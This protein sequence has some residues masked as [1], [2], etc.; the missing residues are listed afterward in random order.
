M[1]HIRFPA[2]AFGLTCGLAALLMASTMTPVLA[3]DAPALAFPGAQGA[4]A[5]THGGRGGRIVRVTTLAA[6]GP[7]SFKEAVTGKGPRIVVFEVGG[8]IDLGMK[9]LRINEPFL[10]IAGQTAPHPGVTLVKG[11][12]TIATHDVVIRHIRVRPGD[13]GLPKRSGDIDAITTVRGAHDVIVDHCSLTWA[14]D[15]NLSASST[16]FHGENEAEWMANASRRIT[17]S[18]NIV[19]EGLANSIHAKGEHSKGSLIHD[20]VNE[21]LIVGNLYA[22]NYERSPLFKGGARGQVINNLIYNPG[23]RAIHYNLIAEEWLGHPYSKG[24]MVVRGNVMRAGKSTEP[25][26]FLMIG[27]S[28]DLDVYAQD[29]LIVD[30]VGNKSIQETGSYT[31]APVKLNRVKNA[32]ALPFGVTLLPSVEVQDAV[33]ENAGATPWNRDLIDRRIVADVIEGRGE[34]IDSQEQVGGYPQYKEARKPFVESEWNLD[35]ME[36]IAGYPRGE[37]LR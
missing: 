16:R 22:H 9:E 30:R 24:E 28:G 23:Q 19:S 6:D 8:V 18:N 1:L 20:H 35:V 13:G 12:L 34:I 25:L 33:I 26:A 2:R 21:V 11:G 27:G 5:H 37:P 15:E 14:T 32:P 17:Y 36:P 4:A 7:G 31:T 3:A 29:N 10:T